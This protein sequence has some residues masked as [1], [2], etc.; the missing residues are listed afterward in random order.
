MACLL[1]TCSV[2]P[3]AMVYVPLLPK[4][5]RP[6]GLLVQAATNI[7]SVALLRVTVQLSGR[8]MSYFGLSLTRPQTTRREARRSCPSG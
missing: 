5:L 3:A 8:L 1:A 7:I 4:V 2:A 6:S